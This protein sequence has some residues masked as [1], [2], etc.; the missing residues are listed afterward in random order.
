MLMAPYKLEPSTS[1]L[2]LNTNYTI[3]S[4]IGTFR[5]KIRILHKKVKSNIEDKKIILENLMFNRELPIY[6]DILVTLFL[7]EALWQIFY[8]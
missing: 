2:L 3:F 6:I 8:R 1:L 4:Y 5:H 7:M